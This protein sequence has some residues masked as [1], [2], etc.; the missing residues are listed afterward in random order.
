M[1]CF[2]YLIVQNIQ[3]IISDLGWQPRENFQTFAAESSPEKYGLVEAIISSRS[4]LN[5][6]TMKELA[7]RH[8]HLINP[9]AIMR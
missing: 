9:L 3:K 7:V 2:L 4:A 8:L 5:G 6:H 1:P